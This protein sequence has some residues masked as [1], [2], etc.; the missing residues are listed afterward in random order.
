MAEINLT[1]DED[2][3]LQYF[4]TLTDYEQD[5]LGQLMDFMLENSDCADLLTEARS[6]GLS[7]PSESLKYMVEQTRRRNLK[8]I[9]GGAS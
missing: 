6:K 2:L 1:P 5:K 4:R 3:F 8:V 7:L 9:D